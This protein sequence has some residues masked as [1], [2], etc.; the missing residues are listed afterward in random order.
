MPAFRSDLCVFL[1]NRH[2]QGQANH[3]RIGH[4]PEPPFLSIIRRIGCSLYKSWIFF[5]APDQPMPRQILA[6]PHSLRSLKISILTYPPCLALSGLFTIALS[7]LIPYFAFFTFLIF[8][9]FLPYSLS[10]AHHKG[11]KYSAVCFTRA[12]ANCHEGTWKWLLIIKRR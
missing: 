2:S 11:Q 5:T 4:F 1:R 7:L 3:S 9:E 8:I 12:W 10:Y 6:R